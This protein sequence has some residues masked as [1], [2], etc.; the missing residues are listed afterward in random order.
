MLKQ[1][2]MRAAVLAGAMALANGPVQAAEGF[3]IRYNLTG[4]L[5]GE[6]FA[7]PNQTGWAFGAAATAVRIDKVTGGDGRSISRTVPGGTV[8]LPAPVPPALY[9]SYSENVATLDASGPLDLVN[10]GVGYVT[11]DQYGGGR[12]AFGVNIPYG[13]KQQTIVANAATPGLQWSPAITPA[14]RAAVAA[15][16]SSQY[17]AGIAAQAAAD[18]GSVKGFGDTEL[19]GG[20]LYADSKLRVVGGA[21]LILPTGKYSFN[22]G[23]D[24]GTGNFY[25]FRPAIQIA[26]LPTPE[27]GLAAKF[28]LGL[29]TRNSDNEL[30]SGNWTGM[31]LAAA[32]KT[33]IGV[34][35]VHAIHVQQYQDDRNN[36]WGASRFR[37]TNAGAFFTTLVPGLNIPFT[38]QYMRTVSSRYAKHGDF[39]QA[40][41]IKFF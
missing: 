21:S 11:A 24:I 27:V 26:Y 41:L 36:V 40:R 18:T 12:L 17:Q 14:T 23:P 29:N 13:H 31:E 5:G 34:L 7:P 30:R 15:Q 35:G 39:F 22:P 28:T 10:F 2:E 38:V 20:W 1:W 37:S 25:T 19:Q 6:I 8:P 32:Y 3:E 9:P 33:A 16:F 4:S